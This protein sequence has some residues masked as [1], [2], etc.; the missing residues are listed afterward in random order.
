MYDACRHVRR[1]TCCLWCVVALC[2]IASSGASLPSD[3]SNA[4]LLYYQAFLL[5]PEPNEAEQELIYDAATETMY[6]YLNGLTID[7]DPD[8]EPRLR[9]L[10]ARHRARLARP[11]K[12][13]LSGYRERSELNALRDRHE[14]Q[15]KLRG[16]DP[17]NA[18]R[19]YVR[20][21]RAAISLAQAA[22]GLSECDWGI[23]HSKGIAFPLS[24]LKATRSFARVLHA[25]ALIRLA[26]GDSRSAI[27]RCLMTRRLAHHM[28]D[29]KYPLFFASKALDG[30]ALS[31]IQFILGHMGP[32]AEILEWLKDE[33]DG[34]AVPAASLAQMLRMD[35]ADVCQSVRNSRKRLDEVREAMR[36]R[37]Q[38]QAVLR[39]GGPPQLSQT[40]TAEGLTDEEIEEFDKIMAALKEE[41]DLAGG[42]ADDVRRPG[43]LTDEALIALAAK[44]YAAFLDAAL[45]TMASDMPYRGK[46]SKLKELEKDIRSQYGND[47][48]SQRMMLTHPERLLGLSIVIACQTELAR[49]Y[50]PHIRHLAHVNVVRAAVEIYLVRAREGHLPEVLPAGLPKDVFT[51]RDFKYQITDEGFELALPDETI[52]GK[53]HSTYQFPVR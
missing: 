5:R 20:R 31:S 26:D 11:G 38:I 36:L 10:E 40:A 52:S 43:D 48:D 28:G 37:R 39:Q 9:E 53:R 1:V 22:S 32:D 35:F 4:A 7:F 25:D 6:D 21:C 13:T 17:N 12:M 44:P 24:Q 51:G 30:R 14:R 23:Q 50:E 15:E 47:R 33:L 41:S 34:E 27:E 46:I 19:D 45:E 18:I 49:A 42:N 8:V 16:V 3:P 2:A 29:E